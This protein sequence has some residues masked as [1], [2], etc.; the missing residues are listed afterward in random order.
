MPVTVSGIDGT[1]CEDTFDILPGPEVKFSPEGAT[2][3]LVVLVPLEQPPDLDLLAPDLP[4]ELRESQPKSG[5]QLYIKVTGLTARFPVE[6][7]LQWQI[8]QSVRVY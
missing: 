3:T 1:W 8:V 5:W 4:P 6:K 7:G 2:H